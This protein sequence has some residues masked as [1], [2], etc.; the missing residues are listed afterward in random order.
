MIL[1]DPPEGWKY[2]FPKMAPDNWLE[3]S[4]QE[5]EEWFIDKGYPVQLIDQGMLKHLRCIYDERPKRTRT[6]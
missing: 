4:E 6:S 2:G 3:M 1:V 5:I